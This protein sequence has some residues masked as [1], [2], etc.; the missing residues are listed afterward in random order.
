MT[1]VLQ[2]LFFGINVG[3]GI[4]Q[5]YRFD[6]LQKR[7]N[8]TTWATAYFLA[9]AQVYWQAHNWY[10]VGACCLQHIPVFNTSL[11]FSRKQQRPFWS[12]LFYTHPDDP[13]GSWTDQLWGKCYPLVFFLSLIAVIIIQFFI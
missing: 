1:V 10:L 3:L 7:I 11:N 4:Y 5:A 12:Q 2:A 9:A 13:L 8:H 6:V